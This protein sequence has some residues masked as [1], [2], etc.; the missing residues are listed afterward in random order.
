M[1]ALHIT[2][3]Q[4]GLGNLLRSTSGRMVLYVG[5]CT[6][7]IKLL[8]P[9]VRRLDNAIHGHWLTCYP[10]DKCYQK[11]PCYPLDGDSSG[12]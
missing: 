8:A 4:A 12:G 2:T 7:F 5:M 6:T 10:V 1:Q 9:V 11:N 3:I